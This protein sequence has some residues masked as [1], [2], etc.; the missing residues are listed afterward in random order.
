MSYVN[1]V[2]V[3]PQ[4][5]APTSYDLHETKMAEAEISRHDYGTDS[6]VSMANSK[7]PKIAA[8]VALGTS[9]SGLRKTFC[10]GITPDITFVDESLSGQILPAHKMVLSKSSPFFFELFQ[11]DWKEKDQDRLPVPGGFQWSV[12]KII[13]DLL[14]GEQVEVEEDLLV[15]TYRAADYLQLDKVKI[16]I[17]KGFATWNLKDVAV[18]LEMC[19]QVEI[20]HNSKEYVANHIKEILDQELDFTRLTKEIVLDISMS[21]KVKVSEVALHAFLTKWTE[22]H[23]DQMS[24]EEVQCIFGNIRYGTIKVGDLKN[25]ACSKYYHTVHLGTALKQQDKSS[26]LDMSV[27]RAHPVQYCSRK[28]QAPF[29]GPIVFRSNKSCLCVVYSGHSDATLIGSINS[30]V[31]IADMII[32]CSSINNESQYIKIEVKDYVHTQWTERRE[33][34]VIETCHIT[35]NASGVRV[36]FRSKEFKEWPAIGASSVKRFEFKG[37]VPWLVEITNIDYL[38]TV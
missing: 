5:I 24:F 34:K 1:S 2:R 10:S 36:S 20:P 11:G 3:T 7:K 17:D 25:M 28:F 37:P 8:K 32:K 12:F 18:A 4:M 38:R 6:D 35:F 30:Y 15:E 27:V 19:M 33:S 31:S 13:I 26:M 22:A 23:I 16:A 21:E 29:P 9:L 14:Y